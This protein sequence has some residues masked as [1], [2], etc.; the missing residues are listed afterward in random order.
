MNTILNQR[1]ISNLPNSILCTNRFRDGSYYRKK[2][3]AITY[4]YIGLNKK[5]YSYTYLT[6]DLDYIGGYYAYKEAEL[7]LP[8]FTVISPDTF[9]S[10]IT[11]E[12]THPVHLGNESSVR[13]RYYLEIIRRAYTQ[14]LNSDV[15][16]SGILT[17]NPLHNYWNTISHDVTYSLDELAEPIRDIDIKELSKR[18]VDELDDYLKQCL[19]TTDTNKAY[20]KKGFRKE[21][22]ELGRNPYLFEYGR[23]FAYSHVSKVES[24][25]ELF[26]V[27]FN[28]LLE[29][30][31]F[32]ILEYFPSKGILSERE[33]INISRSI[34]RFTF[35]NRNYFLQS[36]E[37]FSNRQKKRQI[38]SSKKRKENNEKR[39]IDAVKELRRCN[40]KITQTSISKITNISRFTINQRYKYLL[41]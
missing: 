18:S 14:R 4:K 28:Y 34:T 35:N 38:S 26:D 13:A 29:L 10:H 22:I 20:R 37:K 30:N 5:N 16:Y 36:N 33:V 27:V 17:K 3:E 41:N 8:T 19:I 21:Y 32:D 24:V 1:L 15:A 6:F 7:L 40:K 23:F 9:G 39:I 12:L 11:Y 31:H 2:N 25:E